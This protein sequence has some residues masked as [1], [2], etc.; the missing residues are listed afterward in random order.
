MIMIKNIFFADYMKYFTEG[1]TSMAQTFFSRVLIFLLLVFSVIKAEGN[2]FGSDSLR[3]YHLSEIVVSATKTP[4]LSTQIGSAITV[5]DREQ[6]ALSQKGTV[7]EL[8]SEVPGVFLVQQGGPGKLATVFTRGANAGQTLVLLDGVEM[9]NPGDIGNVFD[10]SNLQADDI[11]RIEILRGP[12]S[13]LY[14]SDAL[15][16]VISI[17]TKKPSQNFNVTAHLEGGSYN[18]LRSNASVSGR[19]NALSYLVSAND[20]KT[21]GFSSA[22]DLYGN[23]EADGYKTS[24][25]TSKLNYSFPEDISLSLLLRYNKANTDFDYNGGI[26]GDDPNYSYSLQESVMK[27]SLDFS[28][29]DKQWDQSISFNYVRNFRKYIDGVDAKRPATSSDARYDGTKTKIEWLNTLNL[30]DNS[31]ITFGAEGEEET[32][33]SDFYSN[34]DWG[35]FNSFFPRSSTTTFGFYAQDQI[36]F[37]HNFNTTI[38]VRYDKHK[39]FG[40]VTT[41]RIAPVYFIEETGT[42]FRATYGTGFKAPSLFNLFDPAYGNAELKSEKSKGWDFGVEQFLLENNLSFEVSYFSNFFTDLFSFDYATFKTVNLAKAETNGVEFGLKYKSKG[43]AVYNF[44]YTL[45]NT[46]DKSDDSPDKDSPLLRRPKDKAS[47]S[48]IFF[49]NEHLN[50]GFEF[51]YT[52][53]RDDKDFS[54][55]PVQR[56]QLKSYMLV[57]LSASYKLTS[58]LEVFGKIHNVF[59]KQYEEI[60]GYG[61]ERLS[62]Y[63]GINF[64]L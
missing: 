17:F 32:A 62:A 11:E 40:S 30:F 14:G 10:F 20:F 60:L 4:T 64:S 22:S 56:I 28:L 51:L 2:K 21:K 54:T 6:I 50:L 13:T 39:K 18:S 29:F 5:I 59:D 34:G 25:F 55:Y 12:Q 33:V 47:F 38:G 8:L 61:T 63:A 48:S 24:S 1:V 43:F 16:G 45:T 23:T 19:I 44:T 37:I 35:P 52:G 42:K 31:R 58:G 41:Y 15:A 36:Y 53:I 26:N 57:N 7:L 27:T 46:H 49:L 9:N 3:T